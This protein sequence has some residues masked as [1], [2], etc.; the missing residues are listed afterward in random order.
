[1]GW[2]CGEWERV[3]GCSWQMGMDVNPKCTWLFSCA[4]KQIFV[5]L[6]FHIC[7]CC[8]RTISSYPRLSKILEIPILWKIPLWD[9]QANRSLW[10]VGTQK[11]KRNR[12]FQAYQGL[13]ILICNIMGH[14]G[15]VV[16]WVLSWSLGPIL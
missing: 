12:A 2:G 3:T 4:I 11:D 14:T 5:G 15:T 10:G 8:L 1:M 16:M 6:S 13:R 9:R 7:F